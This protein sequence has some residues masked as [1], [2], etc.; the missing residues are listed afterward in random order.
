MFSLPGTRS[1]SVPLACALTLALA[2][3]TAGATELIPSLGLT[4][5]QHD[6][7]GETRLYG[8]LALR[9][10]FLWI[11]QSE[12][13]VMY[14]SEE[15]AAG[16]VDMRMWPVT[17]ALWLSPMPL[18]Y[19]GGGVGWYNTTIDYDDSIPLDDETH[20]EFGVH[21]GGGLRIPMSPKVMLDLG[22]RYV[23]MDRVETEF[24]DLGDLDP[25]FWTLSLG[26]AVGL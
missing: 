6:E 25:D 3:N 15:R 21:L 19:A 2:A 24:E 4:K 20:Q 1:R 18:A 13:G 14:R 12:V 23:F 11:L 17:A 8:G 22:G 26:L 16:A 10:D 7:D 9:S 5:T